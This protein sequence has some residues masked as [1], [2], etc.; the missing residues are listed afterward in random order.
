M[1]IDASA[2]VAVLLAEP[3]AERFLQAIDA[4]PACMMSALSYLEASVVLKGRRGD[5]GVQSL[6]ALVRAA[7]ID[8]VA[9]DEEQVLFARQTYDRFGKGAHPAGLNLGDCAS[10]AL[11]VSMGEPLLFKGTDFARTDVARAVE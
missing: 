10:Y 6:D 3:E 9:L 4:D 2:L 7:Q 5:A 8:I 1:V 11:A